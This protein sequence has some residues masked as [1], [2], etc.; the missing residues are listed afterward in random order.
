M[1]GNI[2]CTVK[3]LLTEHK[4]RC[5]RDV[6]L[7]PSSSK[8]IASWQSWCPIY[9]PCTNLHV[10]MCEMALWVL[11]CCGGI[12]S[13]VKTEGERQCVREGGLLMF[14]QNAP[15][16]FIFGTPSFTHLYL[17]LIYTPR[18]LSVTTFPCMALIPL[19]SLLLIWLWMVRRKKLWSGSQIFVITNFQLG[20]HARQY[21][22][23]V[24]LL[25]GT[26]HWYGHCLTGLLLLCV[27]RCVRAHS[28]HLVLK[29]APKGL[30]LQVR[31]D[32]DDSRIS[33]LPP[34]L[35]PTSLTPSPVR[36]LTGLQLQDTMNLND[37]A[38]IRNHYLHGTKIHCEYESPVVGVT[39]PFETHIHRNAHTYA[40]Y[41]LGAPT[42]NETHELSAEH[43]CQKW[44]RHAD[45][46]FSRS[47]QSKDQA[48]D[49]QVM[50]LWVARV[51]SPCHLHMQ[52]IIQIA[53]D[54]HPKKTL[55]TQPTPRG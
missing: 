32:R 22:S 3:S 5:W 28:V 42:H 19:I 26:Y 46:S 7:G 12:R 35:C 6:F 47:D 30:P 53:D 31:N 41:C 52:S 48:L 4:H 16:L 10:W 40:K 55:Y 14:Q 27:H 24:A 13:I 51:Q 33:S 17:F 8:T 21:V 18:M 1:L 37:P 11:N 2:R 20:W 36:L 54:P 29:G 23:R 9:L 49:V 50:C 34:F 38:C 45:P 44:N 25:M 15:C 43:A 39:V